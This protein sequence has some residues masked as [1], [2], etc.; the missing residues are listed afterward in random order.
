[1]GNRWV[2]GGEKGVSGICSQP[3]CLPACINTI[4]ELEEGE[5]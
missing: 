1:M 5:E 4:N 3:A 2:A